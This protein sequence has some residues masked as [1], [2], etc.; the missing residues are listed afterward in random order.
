MPV[1]VKVLLAEATVLYDHVFEM[2]DI[3]DQFGQVDVAIVLGA[4]DVVNP[5]AMTKC[6]R[7]FGMTI[8]DACKAKTA[9]VNKRSMAAGCVGRNNELFYM[10]KTMVFGDAKKVV[11]DLVKAVEYPAIGEARRARPTTRTN[12]LRPAMRQAF[13]FLSLVY[14]ESLNSENPTQRK[15]AFADKFAP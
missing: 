15:F 1:H 9:M 5:A 10:D 7:I 4:Q 6:G 13:F 14:A 3:N 2:E 8:L 12:C 11:E